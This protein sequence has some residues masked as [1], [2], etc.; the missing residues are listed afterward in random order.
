[1]ALKTVQIVLNGVTT[2]LQLNEQ[3]GAYEGDITAPSKS[4]YNQNS[5]HYYPITVKATDEAGNVASMN[6]TDPLL[7][8]KLRLRV[9]ET[10][11]PVITITS[12]TEG[13]F[14]TNN[15]PTISWKVTDDDSGV[16]S[17]TI[18]ITI[19]NG[20][21]ITSGI[22]KS[23]ITNGFQCSYV[24]PNSLSDGSHTIKIDAQ[25][26][27]GN[28]AVQRSVNFKVDTIPPQLSLSSPTNDLKTNKKT[29]TVAGTTND[30]TSSPVTVQV[31]L[32]N[33]TAKNVPVGINGEFS[34]TLELVNGQ[35]TIVVTSTDSAGKKSSI[36]RT[37]TLDT[38]APVL[39]NLTITPEIATTG[40]IVH[41][42]V[43]VTD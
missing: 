31:K 27:D 14:V 35:N 9:K 7:G 43:T 16:K 20:N 3:T 37:V 15:K 39:S 30:A 41:V 6:D 2:S 21:K 38:A 34:T 33:G 22:N 1:M 42:S 25:D 40:Q 23:P 11:K 12:P 19:D 29:I 8:S 17:E 10:Q 18:G 36:T 4:S 5:G 24:I 28:N 13:S 26:N 32:N